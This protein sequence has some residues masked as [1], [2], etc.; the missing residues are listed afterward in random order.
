MKPH[1]DLAAL[2]RRVNDESRNGLLHQLSN[3]KSKCYFP[4]R[5]N[6]TNICTKMNKSFLENIHDVMGL[7][8]IS[9]ISPER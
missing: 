6:S 3:K 8:K 7:M 5:N 2:L 9:E 4:K 1:D